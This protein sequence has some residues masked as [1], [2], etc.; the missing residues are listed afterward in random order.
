MQSKNKRQV[1]N[2]E[3]HLQNDKKT[4]DFTIKKHRQCSKFKGLYICLIQKHIE[5]NF[6]KK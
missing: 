2:A 5:I 4:M 6:I 3:K 1:N